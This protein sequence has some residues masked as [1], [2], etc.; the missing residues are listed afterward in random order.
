MAEVLVINPTKTVVKINELKRVG[1]YIRVSSDS[2]DQENSFVTQYDHYMNLIANNPEWTLV[3][4]YKDDGITGTEMECRDDFNRMYQDCVDGKLDLILTKSISRFARNTYDCIDT[5]R[6][7]KIL[8]VDIIFEKENI[9]TS[10]MTSETELA[11]LSS[12]AQEESISLSQNV[13]LGI[14]HRMKN[15][16]FKQGCIPYGYYLGENGEW[17]INEEQAKIVRLIFNA[18]INGMSLCKIAEELKKAGVIK[19]NGST[20]WGENRIR[21]IIKNERYKGDALLQK[22]YTE[23]FPFKSRT[24]HGEKDMY[25]VKN[26]NPAIVTA[27]IFEKAN[28]LLK[29]QGKRYRPST[30]P[31]EHTLSK[32]I[33]CEECGTMF[34]KKSGEV[35]VYWV[36]RTRDY[37]SKECPT[38]QVA[39]KAVMNAFVNM[40]NRLV[41]NVDIILT[42]MLTQLTEYKDQR[43]IDKGEIANINKEIAE[44]TEQVHVLQNAKASGY[45]EPASFMERMNEIATRTAKLRKDKKFLL[46]N[47]EC[48]QA[49]KKT[50]MLVN[51][52]R[53]AG[54]MGE[55][56]K[57]ALR[58]IVTRILVNKDKDLTFELINGLKLKIKYSEV[59]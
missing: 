33:Y 12:M 28:E 35:N 59:A 42:P 51:Y 22:T 58:K 38:P 52:I 50:E 31:R 36:C 40:Y 44:L 7:F 10:K 32:M 15:G 17:K 49:R 11:A 47:D 9:D 6:K 25:Y 13:R 45:I 8:G 41:N 2:E 23:D 39:E 55:F 56:D 14:Q 53:T 46:G 19:N 20:D 27:E 4:I 34:R 57:K 54:P 37:S 5:T 43:M 26:S 3:D 18:Y 1:A 16:T 29:A 48:E 21:Y 24:N 30:T